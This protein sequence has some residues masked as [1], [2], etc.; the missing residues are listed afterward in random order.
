[1]DTN[2]LKHFCTVVETKNLR[3]A[4]DILG[5][6]HSAL[7]KSLKVLQSE[8]NEKLIDNVGRNI[9]ITDRGIALYPK[10]KAFLIQTES[11]FS[12]E[13]RDLQ[14]QKIGTFEVFST[15]LLGR[16]WPKYLPE[17]KMD[18]HELVPGQLEVQLVE[19]KVDLGITYEPIPTAGLEF[20]T[21]GHLEMGIFGRSG[22]F[23]NFKSED[24]PFVVPITPIGGT[25]S[26]MKGLDGWPDDK[27]RR[28]ILY[29][30]DMMESGLALARA[31][32]ACIYIPR[33]VAKLHNQIVKPEFTLTERHHP[34]SFKPV[35]RKIY[36]IKRASSPETS[37][38]RNVA[39][40]IRSECLD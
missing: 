26:G 25:P 24:L 1:M 17:M 20:T 21:L 6:S 2:K 11:L 12:K 18:L 30:V 39:K 22:K 5:L 4:A 33:F 8:V 7:S 23:S 37:L 34:T 28:N 31:G 15:H 38:F 36:L 40:L 10:L 32:S 14:T 9:V 13:N 35:R 3:K 29:R 27:V 16:L 19:G